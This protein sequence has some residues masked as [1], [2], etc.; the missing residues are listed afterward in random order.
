MTRFESFSGGNSFSGS[1]NQPT[2]VT[3]GNDVHMPTTVHLHLNPPPLSANPEMMGERSSSFQRAIRSALAFFQSP[4]NR[5]V[6]VHPIPQETEGAIG[7]SST[8]IVCCID[9]DGFTRGHPGLEE[10]NDDAEMNEGTGSSDTSERRY[11]DACD[12][13]MV[14][15]ILC[16][17]SL[18]EG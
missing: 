13:I 12:W 4:L 18:N 8:A 2:L 16:G 9:T 3:A 5:D 15:T 10:T 6:L 17:Y 1:H 7:A 11:R 14:R